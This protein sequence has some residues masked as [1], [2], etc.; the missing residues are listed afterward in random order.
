MADY[1]MRRNQHYQTQRQMQK[2]DSCSMQLT[3]PLPANFTVAMMYVPMQTD[4]TI[5]DEMKALECG[6]LFTVLSKPFAGRCCK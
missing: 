1:A 4:T 2:S 5:F 6:T 3:A